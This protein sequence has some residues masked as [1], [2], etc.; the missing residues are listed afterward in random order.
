M[1]ETIGIWRAA[2]IAEVGLF[3]FSVSSAVAKDN[4][5]HY[6]QGICFSNLSSRFEY[7]N[8]VLEKKP[9]P[10]ARFTKVKWVSNLYRGG[11][12]HKMSIGTS[13]R[14]ISRRTLD[15]MRSFAPALCSGSNSIQP[16]KLRSEDPTWPDVHF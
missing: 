15:S 1:T 10:R 14:K 11:I 7:H 16:C 8:G 3:R 12:D 9:L 2:S 13:S 6:G 4:N 5:L